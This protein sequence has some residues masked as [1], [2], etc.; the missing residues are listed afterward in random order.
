ML[1]MDGSINFACQ[2]VFLNETGPLINNVIWIF[3]I[4]FSF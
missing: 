4:C 1:Y 3:I 2:I